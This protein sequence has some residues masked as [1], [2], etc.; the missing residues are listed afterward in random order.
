MS[1]G[2]RERLA[3]VFGVGVDDVIVSDSGAVVEALIKSEREEQSFTYA[4]MAQLPAILGT[5]HIDFAT[6]S[7]SYQGSSWTGSYGH[8]NNLIITAR[9][10]E[11]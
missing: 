5:E 9:R 7:G 11:T 10:S 3:A 6:E 4:Q 2:V 1:G 8:W